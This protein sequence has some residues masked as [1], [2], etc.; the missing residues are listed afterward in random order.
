M[1]KAQV[2]LQRLHDTA[3]FEKNQLRNGIVVCLQKPTVITDYEGYVSV[4][5]ENVGSANDPKG[6]EGM[7]HFLEHMLF[8]GSYKCESE[9]ELKRP[10]VENGGEVNAR[11]NREY[12]EYF[13]KIA[14]Q[15]FTQALETLRAI[16]FE[17]VFK[18]EHVSLECQIILRELSEKKLFGKYLMEQH[19]T[20]FVLGNGD[21]LRHRVFGYPSAI[22]AIGA[23]VLNDFYEQYYHAGNAII[24]CGGSFSLIPNVMELLENTFGAIPSG[25]KS[26][27]IYSAGYKMM[28]G[29]KIFID[30]RYGMD[31][32]STAYIFPQMPYEEY[33]PLQQ[34]FDLLVGDSLSPLVIEMRENRGL[35]YNI[36]ADTSSTRRMCVSV[37]ECEID[38]LNF[39]IVSKLF[40]EAL[41]GL[42]EAR[43]ERHLS[44]NKKKRL[45]N[46]MSPVDSC[47]YL[48]KEILSLGR[49][50]SYRE[51][52]VVEDAIKPADIFAWRDKLLELEPLVLEFRKR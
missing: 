7:A 29:E 17:P 35:T 26:D 36:N 1:K 2:K 14:Q 27:M 49:P 19:V 41:A 25:V 38:S 24:I 15:Y 47:E 22:K 21:P 6:F 30:K 11:T 28:S 9:A 44:K 23:E 40:L 45:R 3:D 18:S 4:L 48:A 31:L 51:M 8:R 13:V 46:F 12:T 20:D 16:V 32:I 43:I 52:E 10:I 37:F 34:L 50:Y 42:D 33:K 39:P 5:F